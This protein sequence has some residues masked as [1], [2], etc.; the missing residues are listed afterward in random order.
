MGQFAAV[1]G[2]LHSITGQMLNAAWTVSDTFRSALDVAYYREFLKLPQ[3]GDRRDVDALAHGD[4]AFE[5]VSF[6]YPGTDRQVLKNVTFRI[7]AGERVAFA[8]EN[9]A[10]KST[11]VKL[12]CGLYEPDAGGAHG[13]RGRAGFVRASA[14]E[15]P[16][17]GVPGFSGV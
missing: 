11:L 12:L 10:G 13:G 8:G 3:R 17:R 7:K 2:S 9:G 15:V 14:E 16:V 1:A 5:N 4:I 6:T